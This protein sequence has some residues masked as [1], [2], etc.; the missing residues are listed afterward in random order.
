MKLNNG[1]EVPLSLKWRDLYAL[2]QKN[3]KAFEDYSA[4]VRKMETKPDELS[5]MKIVY[6]GYLCANP[7][8]AMPFEDFLD[9]LPD[10]H[11]T[12]LTEY[13]QLY[14]GKKK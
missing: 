7:D 4:A 2:E 6:A 1:K 8:E 3:P 13:T 14:R 9:L 10:D 11:L 5:A 12:A